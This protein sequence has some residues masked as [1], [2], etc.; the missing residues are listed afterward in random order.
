[1]PRRSFDLCGPRR[2]GSSVSVGEPRRRGG[3]VAG[4]RSNHCY[5]GRRLTGLGAPWGN[6]LARSTSSS[7][8]IGRDH[9]ASSC[10][11]PRGA[12]QGQQWSDLGSAMARCSPHG[13]RSAV[14]LRKDSRLTNVRQGNR[15]HEPSKSNRIQPETVGR[16]RH[17]P[18]GAVGAF[19]FDAG[20]GGGDP[21]G[22]RRSVFFRQPRAGLRGAPFQM[23][24]FRTMRDALDTHGHLLPDERRLTRLGASSAPPVSTNFLNCSQ[25]CAA[26]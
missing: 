17:F 4:R 12:V 22:A 7:G 25:F 10:R 3:I 24:K 26:R 16:R 2:G 23:R 6:G 13:S 15:I 14:D 11:S 8:P 9:S 20:G 21:P 5:P 18:G 19:A 1:M